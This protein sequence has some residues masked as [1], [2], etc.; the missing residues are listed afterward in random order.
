MSLDPVPAYVMVLVDGVELPP[1]VF[2]FNGLFLGCFP[3][4]A[5]PAIDPFGDAVTK[6][7]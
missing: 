7:A 3:A 6:I 2:V 5:L 1:E 4:V